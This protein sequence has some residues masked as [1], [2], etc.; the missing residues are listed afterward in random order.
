MIDEVEA[1]LRHWGQQGQGCGSSGALGSPLASLIEWSGTAPR[2]TP[3]PRFPVGGGPDAVSQE[4]E[5]ALCEID[6]QDERGKLLV[7][8]ALVRYASSDVTW[9]MQM[10]LID[11]KSQARQT[12]YD[13]VH[14]L[15][16]RV[17]Q[18]L[19]KRAEGRGQLTVRRAG[20]TQSILKVASKS[21][22]AG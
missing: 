9:R 6:R 11:L 12:Y 3:G 5:A 17:L 4:V 15:H 16:L 13:L 18:V 10:H 2:S 8:L 14:A 7:R 22:R 1:L 19:T 20:Q 21:R